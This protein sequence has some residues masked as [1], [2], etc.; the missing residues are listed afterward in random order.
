MTVDGIRLFANRN[1][2]PRSVPSGEYPGVDG[3]YS[4]IDGEEPQWW[5]ED[6]NERCGQDVIGVLENA[7][8]SNRKAIVL[9]REGIAVIDDD[10]A[11]QA[12]RYVDVEDFGRL[13]KDP[14]P[15]QIDLAT[16]DESGFRV[17]V[18]GKSGAIFDVL[19]FLM[20]AVHDSK[21]TGDPR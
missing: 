3:Y 15:E 4:I 10:G 14:V 7:P 1:L 9:G 20:A 13:D 21:G 2:R 17:P 6:W 19:R 5:S 16:R 11:V 18:L 8:G 12:V